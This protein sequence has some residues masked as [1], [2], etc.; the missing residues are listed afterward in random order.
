MASLLTA[1]CGFGR[2]PLDG[3]RRAIQL[4]PVRPG[5]LKRCLDHRTG[6]GNVTCGPQSRVVTISA[7]GRAK[8]CF[9]ASAANRD[10]ANLA[11]PIT[12]FPLEAAPELSRAR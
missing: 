3:P 8:G 2:S 12:P 10:P 4:K 6:G 7:L 5:R 1:I 9:A 11:D